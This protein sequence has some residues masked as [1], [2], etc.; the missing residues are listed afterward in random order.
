MVVRA[1]EPTDLAEA[2]R[3][4]RQVFVVEQGVPVELEQ[5]ERDSSADHL[6]AV[7]DGAALGA[8]RLVVEPAGFEGLDL[9]LGP[10]GHLGRLA[11]SATARG[12]GLGAV[13]VRAVEDRAQE[14]TLA[15]IYLG[16]Q[17]HALGFYQGL[18]YSAFGET[19]DDAGIPHRH[20][21]RTLRGPA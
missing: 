14:L 16:A 21:L 4:R 1:V 3:I 13:L 2:F 10:V 8:V 17:T 5:D 20:M 11:V 12:Q 7:V 15:A 9:G 19:F 18:G 6:L